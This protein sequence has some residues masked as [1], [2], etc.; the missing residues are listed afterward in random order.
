LT[1]FRTLKR[2]N[3]IVSDTFKIVHQKFQPLQNKGLFFL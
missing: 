3:N 1:S 2:E